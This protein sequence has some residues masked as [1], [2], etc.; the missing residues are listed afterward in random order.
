MNPTFE[1]DQAN[2]LI[3][4]IAKN[5]TEDFMD[6]L[7]E[8]IIKCMGQ[9]RYYVNSGLFKDKWT[10]AMYAASYFNLE[11]KVMPAFIIQMIEELEFQ[12]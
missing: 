1:E 7:D 8:C 9:I 3:F 12:D 5:M 2:K 6:K 10:C 4:E 11:T